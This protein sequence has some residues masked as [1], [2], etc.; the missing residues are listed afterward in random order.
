[1]LARTHQFKIIESRLKPVADVFTP[2][3]LIMVGA[4]VDV[5]VFNPFVSGNVPILLIA[6]SLFIVAVIGKLASGWA[7]LKKGLRKIVIGIGM[8]P[9]GEV[10]L[11]FAQM[12]LTAGVFDSRLFSAVTVMVM[13]TT[14]IA[15][16]LLKITFADEAGS[17][18][19]EESWVKSLGGHGE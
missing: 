7:A 15:P 11:I 17:R 3:F 9:R 18:K 8:V 10:G 1:V 12:G 4:A 13:L 14:F 6:L 16:P 19:A 5:R 2:V